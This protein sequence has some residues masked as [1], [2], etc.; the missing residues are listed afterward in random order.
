LIKEHREETKTDFKGTIIDIETIG[1]FNNLYKFDSRRFKGIQQVIL[2]YINQEGLQIYCAQDKEGIEEL[3]KLTPV[4]IEKLAKPLYA[5]N[6]EFESGVWFHHVGVQIDFEG[7]LQS[8]KYESKKNAVANLKIAN[9]DDPF[10]D[11][12]FMCMKAWQANDFD[13]A[14]AHN[15]ACLLKERDILIKR[16]HCQA[17]KLVCIK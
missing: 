16:G 5:F 2:G 10:F 13:K 9:Y 17:S 7:E 1:D 11:M 14:V 3:K 15:R 6:C 4:I 12:G 8:V